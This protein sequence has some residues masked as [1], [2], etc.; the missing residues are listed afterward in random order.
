MLNHENTEAL[1]KTGTVIFLDVSKDGV[2]K[3]LENDTTRPL[4]QRPDRENAISEL[5]SKR[6]SC[7]LDAAD[8]TVNA[9][10]CVET[11]TEEILKQL[12]NI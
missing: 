11:V 10:N 8:I 4:L 3:R 12:K 9:D 7:Y 5:L 2:L 1:K 6:R